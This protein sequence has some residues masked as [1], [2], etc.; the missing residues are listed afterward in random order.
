MEAV[1]VKAQGDMLE[2]VGKHSHVVLFGILGLALVLRWIALLDLKASIYY[3]YLLWDERLYH[4][5]ATKLA[6]GT[7]NSVA[8]YEFPPLPAYAFALIYKLFGPHASHLRILNLALGVLTCYLIF[9]VGKEMSERKVGLLSALMAALYQPFIFYSIVPLKTSLAVFLFAAGSYLFLVTLRKPSQFYCFLLG[10]GSGLL[11]NTRPNYLAVVPFLFLA[12]LWKT[13]SS[14]RGLFRFPLLFIAGISL[15]VSPFIISNF[16]STGRATFLVSEFGYNLYIGNNPSNPSPYYRPVPFAEPSPFVQGIQFQVE[17][18][19]RAGKKLSAE[20]ASS[21]WVGE[22]VSEALSEPKAF[23]RSLRQKTV[24]IFNQFE[25]GDHYHIGFLS[26]HVRFFKW[27]LL[28]F[29]LIMP[30]GMAGMVTGVRRSGRLKALIMVFVLYCLSLVLTYTSTRVR[31]PLLTILI[32]FSALG[33]SRIIWWCKQRDYKCI[34][35]YTITICFFAPIQ[36]LPL[37]GTGD[38]SA[39]YNTHAIILESR[40]SSD[41]AVR[42]WKKSSEMNQAYSAFADLSLAR[43]CFNQRNSERALHYLERI[44]DE[45]FAAAQK[46]ALMGRLFDRERDY[47]K[48]IAAYEKSLQINSG[49]LN[50]QKRFVELLDRVDPPRG[51]LERETLSYLSSFYEGG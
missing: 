15:A 4:T 28:T 30:L 44:P 24:A 11:I 49:D 23:L 18:S 34:L 22:V 45:S 38:L 29:G 46:Y 5:W 6:D 26:D 13:R 35:A 20:E 14:I 32:P 50:A 36:F 33:I 37:A 21:F 19:R 17:A 40:G 9:L 3:D 27:P 42:Y 47:E 39:Y 7:F 41:E 2:W 8:P 43:K 48:A 12:I 25:A 31:L 1:T 51:H 16:L 10:I